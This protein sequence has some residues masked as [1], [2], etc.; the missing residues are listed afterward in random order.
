MAA[1]ALFASGLTSIGCSTESRHRVIVYDQPWASSAAVRNL[2]CAPEL[3]TA[4]AQQAKE[5]ELDFPSRL[6]KAF[7]AAPEC[8]TVAFVVLS[9]HQDGSKGLESKLL[10][11]PGS[12]YWRLRVDFRPGL[13]RQAFTLGPGEGSVRN[14]GDDA[15][16]EVSYVCEAAKNNGVLDVW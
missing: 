5:A 12:M 14:E 8:A 4:C 16:H 7:R 2:W 3:R 11:N 15:E 1:I 9:E 6:S 13:P 10:K